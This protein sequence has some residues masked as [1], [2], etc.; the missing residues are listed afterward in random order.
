MHKRVRAKVAA[1]LIDMSERE[2][3]ELKIELKMID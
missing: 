1:Q 3:L 2:T